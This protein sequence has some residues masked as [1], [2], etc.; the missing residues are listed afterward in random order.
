MP[1]ECVTV[2]GRLAALLLLE[3]KTNNLPS[4][5]PELIQPRSV[6]VTSVGLGLLSAGLSKLTG[7]TGGMAAVGKS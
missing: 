2:V 3:E 1:V 5:L 7:A 4:T 6:N